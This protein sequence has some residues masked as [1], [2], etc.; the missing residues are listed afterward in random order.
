MSASEPRDVSGWANHH[1]LFH[2]RMIEL[3]GRRHSL[4]LINQVLNLVE[5]YSRMYVH[6]VGPERHS[7]AEH[8]EMIEALRDS[9]APRLSARMTRGLEV[10]RARL[11][12]SLT[13]DDHQ[14]DLAVLFGTAEPEM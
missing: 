4:R 12:D 2:R 8:E 9:D 7:I 6:L 13:G 3:S 10:V 14:V 1:Y 5:P 11:A